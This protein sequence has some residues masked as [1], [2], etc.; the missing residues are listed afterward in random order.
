[1]FII[2]IIVIFGNVWDY[3]IKASYKPEVIKYRDFAKKL[4]VDPTS[5][6]DRLPVI[7]LIDEVYFSTYYKKAE[8]LF[9]NNNYVV[10]ES[11]FNL[12]YQYAQSLKDDTFIGLAL[13]GLGITQGR[14]G[15]YSD[16]VNNLNHC[17]KY[18]KHINNKIIKFN[19]VISEIYF[20]LGFYYQVKY[21]INKAIKNYNKSI[22]FNPMNFDAL[23]NQGIIYL[24]E[25]DF[26]NAIKNFSS[27][28]SINPNFSNAYNN[29]GVAY[30]NQ[31]KFKEALHDFDIAIS[32]NQDLSEAYMNRGIVYAENK[33][34]PSAINDF[35]SVMLDYKDYDWFFFNLAYCLHKNNELDKAILYYSIAINL[36]PHNYEAYNNRGI[37]YADKGMLDIAI[38]DFLRAGADIQNIPQ[39]NLGIAYSIKGD[40]Q[41]GQI[42]LYRS[43]GFERAINCISQLEHLYYKENYRK[44]DEFW[45]EY[46][47]QYGNIKPQSKDLFKCIRDWINRKII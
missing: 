18:K 4:T 28:L 9:N 44:L 31:R 20:N 35:T 23:Y 15:N 39:G 14:R 2:V 41:Y 46:G 40:L 38:D 43:G 5:P 36:N 47:L 42:Y 19:N 32:L 27:S 10:A 37:V 1:M 3:R 13:M 17:L 11:L 33:E 30:L 25:G 16:A 45:C 29:R 6:R 21:A 22:K 7:T 8:S 34:Y 26:K 24:H 12:S